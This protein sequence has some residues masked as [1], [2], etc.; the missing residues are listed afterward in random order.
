MDTEAHR[1][2][3]IIIIICVPRCPSVVIIPLWTAGRRAGTMPGPVPKAG[4]E[5]AV[6]RRRPMPVV[7]ALAIGLALGWALAGIRGPRLLARGADRAGDSIA[8]AGPVG[9]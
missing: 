4:K 3:I 5:S 6:N 1:L 2:L 9:A 7:V 8:A